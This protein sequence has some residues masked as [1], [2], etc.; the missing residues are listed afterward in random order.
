V[1]EEGRRRGRREWVRREE[2]G[3][4]GSCFA[5]FTSPAI[6]VLETSC[7]DA[8]DNSEKETPKT[9]FSP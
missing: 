4:H 6:R 3:A 9:N 5:F 2:G 1:K 7:V 8:P